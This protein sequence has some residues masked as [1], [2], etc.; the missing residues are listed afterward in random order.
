MYASLRESG[1]LHLASARPLSARQQL[2]ALNAPPCNMLPQTNQINRHRM[3]HSGHY[4]STPNGQK[5]SMLSQA[6][7]T[8]SPLASGR[9]PLVTSVRP[10]LHSCYT[11]KTI[12]Y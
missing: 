4:P 3:G 6:M 2:G 9:K 12:T 10:P 5:W 11:C 7:T 8:S 1:H